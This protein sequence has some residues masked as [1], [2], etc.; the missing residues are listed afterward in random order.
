[1]PNAE[2]APFEAMARRVVCPWH[3]RCT[4]V[5]GQPDPEHLPW[6]VGMTVAAIAVL[7][8][9]WCA[10]RWERGRW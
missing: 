2:F 9:S 5:G 1:M 7:S 10:A 4:H 3:G 6:L 8:P